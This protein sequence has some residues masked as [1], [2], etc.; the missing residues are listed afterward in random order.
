MLRKRI[1]VLT[2]L[3][4]PR[5]RFAAALVLSRGRFAAALVL[6]RG[7]FAAALGGLLMAASIQLWAAR[8][9]AWSV[10]GHVGLNLDHGDVHLG[11]DF[12]FKLMDVSSFV[13][14]SIWPS[15]AH[16]FIDGGH[17][18][19]LLGVDFPFEFQLGRSIVSLFVGPGFGLAVSDSGEDQWL[20]VNVINGI[21]LNAGGGVRPFAELA[22]RFVNG[23]FV[24]FLTGVLIE[25]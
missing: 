17:D 20:K 22:I 25:I 13:T 24:D 14:L 23:T 15:F 19:E 4:V 12:E 7:R 3:T 10:G 8:A 6:S 1:D 9:E 21:F 11:V 18:V 5:G 2:D 16:V